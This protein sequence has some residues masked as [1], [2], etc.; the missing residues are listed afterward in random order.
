[1]HRR[2]SLAGAG[3]V[4]PVVFQHPVGAA[5]GGGLARRPARQR[6]PP[7]VP[8][9]G[10]SA[11]NSPAGT[12]AAA[13]GA[14]KPTCPGR[15][16]PPR[17][18]RRP[19]WN[20]PPARTCAARRSASAR[21][22]PR[23]PGPPPRPR[24]HRRGGRAGSRRRRLTASPVW[25]CFRSGRRSFGCPHRGAGY[26]SIRLAGRRHTARSR[27]CPSAAGPRPRRTRVI[28]AAPTEPVTSSRCGA[29]ASRARAS[30]S[31]LSRRG[32]MPY[33][34]STAIAAA[35]ACTCTSGAGAVSRFATSASITSPWEIR[36][37]R[38]DRAQLIDDLRDPQPPPEL[39]DHRQ[40][41]Q[42]L[43]QHPD[44]R[45]LRPCP[46]APAA[47]PRH[48][49]HTGCQLP[50]QLASSA[51]P[52]TSSPNQLTANNQPTGHKSAAS[53]PA[54]PPHNTMCEGRV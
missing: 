47:S 16:S 19:A 4:H 52:T 44:H 23:S 54:P 42:A 40:R 35:H 3:E 11:A 8:A 29:I 41:T 7:A 43:L 37:H 18:C 30:R 22:S 24:R 50:D 51:P 27:S 48:P 17:S 32:S 10:G 14:T 34:S 33:A 2:V 13:S 31:S 9:P 49:T 36:R 20:R 15:P 39:R 53:T 38:P 25:I 12:R 21:S 1:M 46:P 28:A 26:S 5:G 6:S 45:D